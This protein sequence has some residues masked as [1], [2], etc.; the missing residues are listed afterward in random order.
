M[1]SSCWMVF[2]HWCSTSSHSSKK[3]NQ[4]SLPASVLISLGLCILLSLRVPESGEKWSTVLRRKPPWSPSCLSPSCLTPRL[5]VLDLGSGERPQ[6]V[7]HKWTFP[8]PSNAALFSHSHSPSR[9]GGTKVQA[10]GLG[11]AVNAQC[12]STCPCP[13]H[14]CSH[15]HYFLG[16]PVAPLTALR[17]D[18]RNLSFSPSSTCR[19]R[20]QI[21]YLILLKPLVVSF[22][23]KGDK[24]MCLERIN[25]LIHTE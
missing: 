19:T 8:T 23:K 15:L 13:R 7:V 2:W 24:G 16:C 14:P 17:A 4:V 11:C 21:D 10:P 5:M 9:G 20:Y 25:E 12:E 18:L 22:I 1:V 6:I 3:Q